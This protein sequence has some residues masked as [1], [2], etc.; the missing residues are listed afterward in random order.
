MASSGSARPRGNEGPRRVPSS[1][2]GAYSGGCLGCPRPSRLTWILNA[3]G[4][5][6]RPGLGGTPLSIW[7]VRP[8]AACLA[9]IAGVL[10]GLPTLRL[11]GDFLAIVTL[12]FGE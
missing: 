4:F 9:A 2:I 1:V 5:G 12:G 10:I 11:R 6:A 8:A 3:G 7:L